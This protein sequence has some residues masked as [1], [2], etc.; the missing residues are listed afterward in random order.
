MELSLRMKQVAD[1]VE[2]CHVAADIGCDHGYVSIY[3]IEQGLAEHVIA[4]DVRT[5]PL[6]RAE[7]NVKQKHLQ[8]KI[9]CRLSDGLEKLAPGE[10]DTIVIAG[11]GGPLMVRI[12]EQGADKRLGN[13]TLILQPQSD[14]PAVRQYLHRIGYA[15]EEEGMLQEDGK[16]Y[17]IMKAKNGE[18]CREKW[19][20]AEYQYGK[21]LLEQ[22]SAVLKQYLVQE[23]ALLKE[24]QEKLTRQQT[25]KTQERLEEI[26]EQLTWNQE[27]QKA[28]EA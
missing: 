27:A 5:G 22:K 12:L 24:L 20:Q 9:Q 21:Y 17:T 25:P 8:T 18:S 14:I 7:Q 28:Y 15:I 26:K 10:A 16:Y 11:M 2:P 6:S 23:E 1:M 13:E 19:S 3:L 4:M